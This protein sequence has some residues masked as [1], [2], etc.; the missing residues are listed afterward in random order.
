MVKRRTPA[1][2]KQ[3]PTPDELEV[4]ASGAEQKNNVVLDPNAKRD[5]KALNVRLNEY[6][7]K[8]LEEAAAKTGRSKMNLIRWAIL[9]LEQSI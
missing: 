5:F 3:H 4:F 7:F 9:S 2:A 8:K 6:E 1:S